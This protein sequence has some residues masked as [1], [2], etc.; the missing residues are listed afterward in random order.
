MCAKPTHAQNVGKP[1][2]DGGSLGTQEAGDHPG[3][4][5]GVALVVPE[6]GLEAAQNRLVQSGGV[7]GGIFVSHR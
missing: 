3:E 5:V 7:P 4:G 1:A 2:R 6:A